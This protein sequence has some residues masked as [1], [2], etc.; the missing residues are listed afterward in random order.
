MHNKID[1]SFKFKD[2]LII[3]HTYIF[4][5]HKWV[6]QAMGLKGLLLGGFSFFK[7]KLNQH[8]NHL[9]E[10]FMNEKKLPR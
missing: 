9:L 4:N 10:K 7:S 3:K 8:S 6:R 5:L 2:G 1:A